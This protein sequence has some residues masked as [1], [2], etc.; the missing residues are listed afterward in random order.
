MDFK[1]TKTVTQGLTGTMI[2]TTT[3]TGTGDGSISTSMRT[4]TASTNCTTLLFLFLLSL[5]RYE[6]YILHYC[7]FK[8][9]MF[10]LNIK[11]AFK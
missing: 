11:N 9:V 1:K 2:S 3:G 6:N 8:T 4:G 7:M 10:R 5:I